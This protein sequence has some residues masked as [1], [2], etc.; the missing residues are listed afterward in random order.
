MNLLLAK[1]YKYPYELYI[2]KHIYVSRYNDTFIQSNP[3]FKATPLRL[4]ETNDAKI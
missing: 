1:V 2:L 4:R 3:K